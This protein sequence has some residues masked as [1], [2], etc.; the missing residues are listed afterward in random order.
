ME[1]LY[2]IL[3]VAVVLNILVSVST[4]KRDDFEKGQKIAQIVLI[5]LVPFIT[6]IG[7]WFFHR[8]FDETYKSQKPSRGGEDADSFDTR[9]HNNHE[10]MG[11]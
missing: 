8:S 9:K 11:D 6:A 2:I 10:H 1:F 5:W 4:F 3:L 7:I